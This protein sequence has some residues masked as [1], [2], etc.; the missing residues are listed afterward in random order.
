MKKIYTLLL[1]LTI[2]TLTMQAQDTLYIY[3][4][5]IVI[6]KHA[7]A[8]V[9]SMSFTP[10]SPFAGTFVDLDGNRY[11]TITIGNQTWMAENLKTTKFRNGENISRIEDNAAWVTTD[12]AAY[13][14]YEN[15]PTNGDNFGHLYNWFATTDSRTIAPAGW[16][17]PSADEW[18]VLKDYL[19]ANGYNSTESLVDN[20]IAKSLAS[21][22]LW[23]YSTGAG[24]PGN[25]Q[26]LNNTSGFNA[27]PVGFRYG[28]TGIYYSKYEGSYFWTN[29]ENTNEEANYSAIFY[30]YNWFG[31]LISSKRLGFSIRCIK[32]N[33]PSITTVNTSTIT[34]S[35]VTTGGLITGNGGDVI[36]ERGVCWSINQNPTIANSRNEN[37]TN[38]SYFVSTISNLSP[39]T[40]Y[41]LKAYA[42]NSV[43][44]A[45]GNEITFTTLTTIP[46][47]NTT[48]VSSITY[49]S[50]MS[51]GEVT[52]NG[53]ASITA[54]GVCWSIS[55][56]P[57][58]ANSKTDEGAGLGIYISSITNLS[59]ITKY[60]IRSYA[61]N[62]I[63]TAYGD[64]KSFTTLAAIPTISTTQ[65]TAITHN[66]AIGGG[67]ISNNGGASITVRG[68]CW[69]TNQTP[70]IADSKTMDGAGLGVF[71]SSIS[72]LSPATKYYVRSYSTN[73]IGTAYGDETSFTTLATIPTI[74]TSQITAITDNSA[75]GGG[76]VSTDGGAS[77]TSRGICWSTNQ[78]PTIS[79]SKTVDGI[80]LG[81]YISTIT[82]LTPLTKYYVRSYSTNS[83]GTAYGNEVEFETIA[84]P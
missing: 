48:P 34:A 61:T 37:G 45:Y 65:I 81:L 6:S 38:S 31:E 16:H 4:S 51:G 19:I 74:S 26:S 57:T 73:S 14:D 54:R 36:T 71:A 59:P 7:I 47:T 23:N 67:D 8:K 11:H 10:P 25:N 35:T 53:G 41:Y 44:T 21:K 49:N 13:C 5:G 55:T 24:A 1:L 64:E 69:S 28:T 15:S 2:V 18:A 83:I 56:N 30:G 62:N 29:T 72:N 76:E 12:L 20:K 3:R 42:V 80:G 52:T 22:S 46:T 63:G 60:Y 82:N 75:I 33:L 17:V 77:I 50:A 40:K 9:D 32:S 66:S 70:T 39:G 68:V 27:L 84:T 58:I 79:D 78:T 43:G